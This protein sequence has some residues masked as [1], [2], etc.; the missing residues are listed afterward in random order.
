[1]TAKAGPDD[2][3]RFGFQAGHEVQEF[4]YDE[5][6]DLEVRTLIESATGTELVDEDHG[7]VVDGALI[8]W[9]E[10]DA[11]DDDLTDVIVEAQSNLDD[12]GTIL[13]MTPKTG[14]PGHVSPADVDDAA[15]TA[16]LLGSS[17]VEGG[18]HWNG[19]RLLVRERGR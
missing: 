10:G 12:G 11:D 19:I 8:W 5:D 14:R 17:A 3:S 18:E 16:G 6:V 4:G 9:R 7:D 1:M 15:R 2:A 13:I